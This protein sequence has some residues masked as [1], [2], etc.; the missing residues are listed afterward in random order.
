M[1]RSLSSVNISNVVWLIFSSIT[2]TTH[3]SFIKEEQGKD[4]PNETL[5]VTNPLL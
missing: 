5:T 1:Q 2:L 3:R 4:Q